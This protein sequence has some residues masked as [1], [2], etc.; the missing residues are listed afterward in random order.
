MS[1]GI[2]T[3]C[4]AVDIAAVDDQGVPLPYATGKFGTSIS[5]LVNINGS[6]IALQPDQEID[7]SF[8]VGGRCGLSVETY[9]SIIPDTYT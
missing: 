8:N 1:T 9:G 5:T 3:T 2:K 7:I 4:C 6:S